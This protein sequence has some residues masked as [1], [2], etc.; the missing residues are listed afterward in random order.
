[1]TLA[2]T[3]SAPLAVERRA[4]GVGSDAMAHSAA[5]T[6]PLQSSSALQVPIEIFMCAQQQQVAGLRIELIGKQQ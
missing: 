1:M 4:L 5:P 6:T 2:S 3:P